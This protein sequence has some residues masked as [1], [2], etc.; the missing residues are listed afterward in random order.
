[1]ALTKLALVSVLL[2]LAQAQWVFITSGGDG[3]RLT[4]GTLSSV[5]HRWSAPA[6]TR[7]SIPGLSRVIVR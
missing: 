1:M 2:T 7:S 5:T 3:V 4:A 6:W